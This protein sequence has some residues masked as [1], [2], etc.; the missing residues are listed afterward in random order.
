MKTSRAQSALPSPVHLALA[1][2][3]RDIGIARR[4]RGIT[5]GQLALKVLVSRNT[6]TRLEQGSPRVAIGI[7]VA[8]LFA[9]ELGDGLASLA[10]PAADQ[11][12]RQCVEERLT[13]RFHGR[14]VAG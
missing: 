5:T 6:I 7:Y 12:G 10:N 13:R 9:L 8:V 11:V 1:T 3:G 2:L 4:R 14:A